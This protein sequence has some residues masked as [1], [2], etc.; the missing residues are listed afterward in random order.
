MDFDAQHPGQD[1]TAGPE[2]KLVARLP[3]RRRHIRITAG[4]KATSYPMSRIVGGRSQS[5]ASMAIGA[6]GDLYLI[7]YYSETINRIAP[8]KLPQVRETGMRH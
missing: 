2:L 5:V 8:S 4:G 6:N 7:D 1:V 3:S